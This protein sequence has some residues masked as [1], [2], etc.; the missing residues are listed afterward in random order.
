[1]RKAFP[2][3][4]IALLLSACA[5]ALGPQRTP[6]AAYRLEVA[7]F[8]AQAD[9]IG[10]RISLGLGAHNAGNDGAQW[11]D[12]PAAIA[13]FDTVLTD[14]AQIEP[15]IIYQTA[16]RDMLAAIEAFGLAMVR[17]TQYVETGRQDRYNDFN[18]QMRSGNA[19]LRRL[20]AA[21][22]APD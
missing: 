21:V 2:L 18:N 1:M 19:A 11:A 12:V 22:P 6:E 20:V 14:A 16:H 8:R 3:L 15:P 5:V 4:L 9:A 13:D 17:L 10:R 7:E